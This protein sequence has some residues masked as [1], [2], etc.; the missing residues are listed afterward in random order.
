M[1]VEAGLVV[2]RDEVVVHVN[3][4]QTNDVALVILHL[5]CVC[6]CYTLVEG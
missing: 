6:I 1:N 2:G 5:S 3:Y 4:D